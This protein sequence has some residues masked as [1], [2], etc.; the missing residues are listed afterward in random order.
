MA[1]FGGHISDLF[2]NSD[3][4]VFD[5]RQC[6][7]IFAYSRVI[8]VGPDRGQGPPDATG[9]FHGRL[10]TFSDAPAGLHPFLRAH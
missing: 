10:L 8:S 9:T 7:G 4:I 3:V 6:S 5:F 1:E 2:P